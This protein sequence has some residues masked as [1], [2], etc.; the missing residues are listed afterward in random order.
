MAAWR[1]LREVIE[2]E[3]RKKW[4]EQTNG[5][6]R[7]GGG[8]SSRPLEVLPSGIGEEAQGD[9]TLSCSAIRLWG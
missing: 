5:K 1:L 3:R 2:R 9:E 7:G 8:L 6:L 4:Q